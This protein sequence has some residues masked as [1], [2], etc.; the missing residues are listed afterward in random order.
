MLDS[1]LKLADTHLRS[2]W[3]RWPAIYRDKKLLER[4]EQV[5]LSD[6]WTVRAASSA[7]T[8]TEQV[9]LRFAKIIGAKHTLLVASGT[10]ALE[11]A[12]RSLM[13]PP[14][15]EVIV[16]AMGWFATAAAVCRAG[17]K[18]VFADIQKETS[19]IDPKSVLSLIT[20]RT[21]AIIAVHLHCAVAELGELS[22]LAR[23]KG[24]AL[25]EDCAQSAGAYYDERSVGTWGDI[26][27]FS[28]NQEKHIAA[29]EGGAIVTNSNELY[30]RLYALRTDGYTP[31]DSSRSWKPNGKVLGGNACMSEFGAA[32]VDWQLERFDKLHQKRSHNAVAL[33]AELTKLD[34]VTSLRTATLT[35]NRS[36]YEFGIRIDRAAFNG[37]EVVEIARTIRDELGLSINRT[38]ELVQRCALAG[39]QLSEQEAP[40]AEQLFEELLVFHHRFL[41]EP[42]IDQLLSK[43]LQRLQAPLARKISGDQL[44]SRT[45][46]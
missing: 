18:P 5:L 13:L 19:C 24:I 34:G 41:L 1:T 20:P 6:V 4:L 43:A 36:W 39:W 31:L 10:V 45:G 21:A 7:Q 15:S 42:K 30:D 12:L 8:V 37:R 38:D 46:G 9:E 23:Q 28:F 17:A 40:N 29:G 14:R 26:G 25:I 35:S 22:A 27:C 44:N 16:P 11:L 2:G 33:E 32:I 3:P